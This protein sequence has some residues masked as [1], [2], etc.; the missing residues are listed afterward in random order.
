MVMIIQRSPSL[1]ALTITRNTVSTARKYWAVSGC[2][3]CHSQVCNAYPPILQCLQQL[4]TEHNVPIVLLCAAGKRQ[5]LRNSRDVLV[6]GAPFLLWGAVIIIIYGSSM[7]QLDKVGC[8]DVF[9]I[10]RGRVH[11]DL[12]GH[13]PRFAR[14]LV[15]PWLAKETSPY[16]IV[17][18]LYCTSALHRQCW[19]AR[20][21]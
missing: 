8:L 3:N 20:A 17:S 16:C 12:R 18:L 14:W 7:Q 19:C 10:A 13:E 21:N 11:T 9:C 6:V 4:W 5:L 15:L 2:A 1:K